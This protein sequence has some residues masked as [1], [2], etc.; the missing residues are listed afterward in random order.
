MMLLALYLEAILIDNSRTQSITVTNECFQFGFFL[1]LPH[2]LD[3]WDTVFTVCCRRDPGKVPWVNS[4]PIN[5]GLCKQV[6]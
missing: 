5:R 1:S 3:L 2:S 4:A 6:A